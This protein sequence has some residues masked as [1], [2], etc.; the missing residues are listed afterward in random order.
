[1]P[2]MGQKRT[3]ET[4]ASMSALHPIA[5]VMFC[6]RLVEPDSAIFAGYKSSPYCKS[7]IVIASFLRVQDQNYK[8]PRF[9]APERKAAPLMGPDLIYDR[10]R[11]TLGPE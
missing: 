2:E 9:F 6:C 3:F 10:H 11:I 7:T 5:D 1:M 8:P 4:Y